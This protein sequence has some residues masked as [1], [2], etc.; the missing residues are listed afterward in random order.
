MVW[1]DHYEKINK[2]VI[3]KNNHFEIAIP[4]SAKFLPNVIEGAQKQLNISNKLVK[5]NGLVINP[6]TKPANMMS[7]K[8]RKLSAN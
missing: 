2:Y 8:T 4:N 5:D 3:V 6:L 7:L 1:G